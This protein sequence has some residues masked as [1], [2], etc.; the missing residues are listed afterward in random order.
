MKYQ[1]SCSAPVS[2]TGW[3]DHDESESPSLITS[4]AL[5]HRDDLAIPCARRSTPD[6]SM[7]SGDRHVPR[8]ASIK[9]EATVTLALE[10]PQTRAP[11]ASQGVRPPTPPPPPPSRPSD[12]ELLRTLDMDR[13]RQ[14]VSSL[15]ACM[16]GYSCDTSS[17]NSDWSSTTSSE[18]D[19]DSGG[20]DRPPSGRTHADADADADSA[21]RT[22]S[23]DNDDNLLEPAIASIM[24]FLRDHL[25]Q[26]YRLRNTIPDPPPAP[27]ADALNRASRARPTV[28]LR[29]IL[30][31]A[32]AFVRP[33]P[34]VAP[35]ST[36]PG[37]RIRRR[38]RRHRR[39]A[40]PRRTG[41]TLG[42]AGDPVTRA[43]D[44]DPDTRAMML[45]LGIDIEA[46]IAAQR[47]YEETHAPAAGASVARQN[48]DDDDDGSASYYS[49]D[50][51]H[52]PRDSMERSPR[53]SV[54]SLDLLEVEEAPLVVQCSICYDDISP[55]MAFSLTNC[56]HRFCEECLSSYVRVQVMELGNVQHLRCPGIDCTS[57]HID[58][59]V[60]DRVTTEEIRGKYHQWKS[61]RDDPNN[62]TCPKCETIVRRKTKWGGTKWKKNVVCSECDHKFCFK[63]GDAHVGSTCRAYNSRNGE[64][65]NKQWKKKHAKKCPKCKVPVEKS[66]GCNHMECP[67]GAAWC[68]LCG[69]H[70]KTKVYGHWSSSNIFGC[71]GGQM[72]GGKHARAKIRA[73]KV[74]I[75][76][77]G[78]GLVAI[79]PVILAGAII[80]SPF[81]AT[82][83]VYKAVKRRAR[84]R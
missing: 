12:A 44:L 2:P 81:Y 63:H 15:R 58:P 72:T 55:A 10:G 67:C 47:A 49:D 13:V 62:T 8:S 16:M 36:R 23:D 5:A 82:A 32:N 64:N 59:A 61:L 68:W 84:R 38:R 50:D 3:N 30:G 6:A 37:R 39:S 53:F 45:N 19:D 57:E 22:R 14:R 70:L 35:T 4:S 54:S 31:D 1:Y 29:E 21:R 52:M 25:E 24:Q 76:A 20:N 28:N 73:K 78:M 41:S 79:S 51:I 60:F 74:G 42:P 33:R 56:E 65:G 80:A 75:V 83:K 77:G 11:A 34:D 48:D 7:K 26:Q 17:R 18:F 66:S 40:T 43:S 46:S 69:K 9:G 27:T 71:P